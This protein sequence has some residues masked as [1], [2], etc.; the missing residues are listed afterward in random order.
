MFLWLL[1]VS[2]DLAADI[3][4][5]MHFV[6]GGLQIFLEI[7]Y[8]TLRCPIGNGKVCPVLPV[9]F[10]WYVAWRCVIRNV[11]NGNAVQKQSVKFLR[12]W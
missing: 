11:P 8:E 3:E 6:A 10:R 9:A 4:I 7:H 1:L 5:N 12:Y 2:A